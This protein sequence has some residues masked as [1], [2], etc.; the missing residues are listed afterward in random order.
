MTPR[1][2]AVNAFR[3]RIEQGNTVPP[4]AT[5][6]ARAPPPNTTVKLLNK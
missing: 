6:Y 4:S 2:K 5:R 1:I 3:P